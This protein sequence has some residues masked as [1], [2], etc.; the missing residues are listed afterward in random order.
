MPLGTLRI[1]SPWGGTKQV[2]SN[3]KG[4]ERPISTRSAQVLQTAPPDWCTFLGGCEE[5]RVAPARCAH[6]SARH[7]S[8]PL[9]HS[10]RAWARFFCFSPSVSSLCCTIRAC[11]PQDTSPLQ[12]CEMLTSGC[13]STVSWGVN[14]VLYSHSTMSRKYSHSQRRR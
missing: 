7:G 10:V 6:S 9:P 12:P 1:P 11:T 4:V 13:V 14:A 8:S 5:A 3:C 2:T